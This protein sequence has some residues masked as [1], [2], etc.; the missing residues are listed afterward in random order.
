MYVL[1]FQGSPRIKGNTHFL[2][3]AFLDEFRK[4]GAVA[5]L[6]HAARVRVTPC[7]GCG[8]C[9]KKGVC[10]ISDDEMSERIYPMLRR[11][12]VVILASPVYFYNTPAQLK[13]IIDRTQTLWARKYR[14]DLEDPGRPIRKGFMLSVGATKGKNLF[15]GMAL[16]ARY[17][18]DAIGSEYTDSLTYRRVE[19]PGDIESVP[20]LQ[21]D[22]AASANKVESLTKRKK[23][24]F[25]CR[26]NACRSQM[27]AGFAR[28]LAGDR[29]D[30]LDAGSTPADRVN[31]EMQTV[32]AEK[33]IDMAFRMPRSIDAVVAETRADIV[34]TMGCGEQCP[35]IPGVTYVDWELPDPAGRGM[36]F[37]RRVR[38]DIESRVRDLLADQ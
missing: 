27:A 12:D 7:R 3:S 16:T 38:D 6:V 9:E 19:D 31:P 8:F 5:E 21:D 25:A 14:H 22:I 30:A 1:G 23:I 35:H 28:Y 17:F 18:F 29:I 2:L 34:V 20:G 37:M 24:L 15:D 13:A 32:M 10:A 33:G 11:A 4:K 36:D 26:E